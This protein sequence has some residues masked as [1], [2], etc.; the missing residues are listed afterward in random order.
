MVAALADRRPSSRHG[1]APLV[2]VDRSFER[3]PFDRENHLVFLDLVTILEQAW[4]EEALH[5]RPKI[6]VDPENE[7]VG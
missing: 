1:V 6:E 5:S 2:L 7:T 4:A 3:L